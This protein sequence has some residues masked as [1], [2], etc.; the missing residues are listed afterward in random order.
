M[1]VRL[2]QLEQAF[3]QI[4][5]AAGVRPDEEYINKVQCIY[6]VNLAQSGCIQAE[7]AEKSLK[8]D[9]N[10]DFSALADPVTGKVARRKLIEHLVLRM[11]DKGL[12]IFER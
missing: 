9:F 8:D 3:E 6:F 10:K 7:L 11:K 12:I 4:L 5:L 1:S 2:D